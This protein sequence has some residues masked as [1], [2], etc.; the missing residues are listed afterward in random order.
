MRQVGG[1]TRGWGGVTGTGRHIVSRYD[2]TPCCLRVRGG[3]V[4]GPSVATE[5]GSGTAMADLSSSL[6]STAI[7]CPRDSCWLACCMTS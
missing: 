1:G 7:A 4:L 5:R 2:V 3:R 6:V